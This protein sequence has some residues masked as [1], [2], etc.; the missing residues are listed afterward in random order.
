LPIT[1]GKDAAVYLTDTGATQ[2]NL[3]AF[4]DN[5]EVSWEVDIAESTTFGSNHRTKIKGLE[6]TTF[7]LSG[8]FDNAG[9]GTPDQWL[10]A[11]VQGTVASTFF[12]FPN[13]SAASRPYDTGSAWLTSY[14]KSIP[15]DDI[16][17]WSADFEVTGRPTRG[18]A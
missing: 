3:T 4:C 11:L 14:T 8:K 1:H 13:G 16:V 12:I 15:V 7:T 17:T 2:R 9:T 6:D 18:T 10:A 5:V